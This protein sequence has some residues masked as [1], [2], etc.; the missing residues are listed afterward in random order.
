MPQKGLL[1]KI[2]GGIAII[3]LLFMPLVRGC[4]T[5]ITGVQA[6]GARDVGS[7]IKLL[8]IIAILCALA[9]FFMK[10]A[11]HFFGSGGGGLFGLFSAYTG[12]RQSFPVE[13]DIGAFTAIIGFILILA[14]GI[15]QKQKED[16]KSQD[17]G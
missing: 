9:A 10:K 2:G 7:G 3:S 5:S 12:A 15:I 13:M 6:I 8:L 11:V 17:S 4:G 16:N 14:E 1:G